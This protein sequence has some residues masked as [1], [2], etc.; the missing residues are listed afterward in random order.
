M[1]LYEILLKYRSLVI[2]LGL[3]TSLGVALL[4]HLKPPAKKSPPRPSPA[5]PAAIEVEVNPPSK[6]EVVSPSNTLPPQRNRVS[7]RPRSVGS[8]NTRVEPSQITTGAKVVPVIVE[9]RSS[10]VVITRGNKVKQGSGNGVQ[11]Q[12]EKDRLEPLK[13]PTAATDAAMPF[14][15]PPAPPEGGINALIENTPAPNVKEALAG[16]IR[17]YYPLVILDA[18]S[19]GLLNPQGKAEYERQK[20][21]LDKELFDSVRDLISPTPGDIPQGYPQDLIE[22]L[23]EEDLI[24]RR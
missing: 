1:R 9:R 17:T 13:E 5:P 16:Y 8:V 21:A 3:V 24:E 11:T 12:T 23:R 6:P 19:I 22:M 2:A 10:A 7:P 18:E 15:A 4:I 20:A 14:F